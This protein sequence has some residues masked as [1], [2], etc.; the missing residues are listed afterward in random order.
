MKHGNRHARPF[1]LLLLCTW[2]LSGASVVLDC[3]ISKDRVYTCIEIGATA[4][5]PGTADT[6][7]DRSDGYDQEYARYIEAAR[8]TCVYDEPPRRASARM[9]D[10]A[11]R[12][13]RLKSAR[14]D[15]EKCVA[16]TARARWLEDRPGDADR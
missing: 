7:G 11:L 1:A 13:E 9:R 15:Y 14:A 8:Q 3:E 4:A 10:G 5:T 2:P 6:D 12:T 16:E